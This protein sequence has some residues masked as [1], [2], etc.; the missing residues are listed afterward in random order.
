[1]YQKRH[2]AF[3]VAFIVAWWRQASTIGDACALG[4]VMAKHQMAGISS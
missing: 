4:D 3:G 1:M 2:N